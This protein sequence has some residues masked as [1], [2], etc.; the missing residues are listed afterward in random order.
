[1]LNK[2]KLH[3]VAD[4]SFYLF[5]LDDIKKP[6]YLIRIVSHFRFQFIVGKKVLDEVKT[7]ESYSSINPTID[8]WI[9]HFNLVYFGEILRPFFSLEE[10][11]RGE[12]E[13]IAIS[14]ILS[15]LNYSFLIVLDDSS[16]RKF[17][18]RMFPQIKD[19]MMGTLGFLKYCYCNERVLSKSEICEILTLMP[20]SKFRIKQE[21][22]DELRVSVRC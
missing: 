17:V 6:N 11:K 22:V 3:V 9:Q 13:V 20:N 1:M 18:E 10:I 2:K 15:E 5:F 16:A 19:K 8:Q 14:Y 7:S 4:A 21:T 12:N